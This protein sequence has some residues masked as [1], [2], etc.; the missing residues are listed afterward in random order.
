MLFLEGLMSLVST[1]EGAQSLICE[2]CNDTYL[3]E[4]KYECVISPLDTICPNCSFQ[5][6]EIA[7]KFTTSVCPFCKWNPP[8]QFFSPD[9]LTTCRGCTN[10][11]CSLS[12]GLSQLPIR[13]CPVCRSHSMVLRT[14]KAG[15]TQF[16]SCSHYPSCKGAINFPPCQSVSLSPEKCDAC[17]AKF[18]A[19]IRKLNFT[20]AGTGQSQ[21]GPLNAEYCVAG[22]SDYLNPMLRM[23]NGR[24]EN[25]FVAPVQQQPPPPPPPRSQSNVNLAGSFQAMKNSFQKKVQKLCNCGVEAAL[26]TVKKEGPNVGREFYGCG[27]SR[28]CQFFEWADGEQPRGMGGGGG[29]G[30][31]GFS[32]NNFAPSRSSGFQNVPSGF[33]N[34]PPPNSFAPSRS[35]GFQ[36][37]SH[38]DVLCGCGTP[39]KHLVSKKE[40]P[41]Q[42]RAFYACATPRECKFFKWADEIGQ[43]GS[44]APSA[45][46][47]RG[48]CFNCNQPGHWS[49]ACPNRGG[50]GFSAPAPAPQK[51]GKQVKDDI[52]SAPKKRGRPPKSK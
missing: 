16:L 18:A 34:G 4:P 23:A 43:Q 26:M 5:A 2:A 51:R 35:S 24:V 44:S 3:L 9:G 7:S 1:D 15:G 31:G 37:P 19:T 10:S 8:A 6:V 17:S 52:N 22:C 38:A 36:N 45:S 49:N 30:G 39:A 48:V 28:T 33:Q 27:N 41:N 20:F 50:S 29:G 25:L 47:G 46:A 42:G 14:P 11:A 40:G 13:L 21:G 32:G 12:K